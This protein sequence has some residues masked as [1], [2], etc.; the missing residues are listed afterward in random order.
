MQDL[1]GK[2]TLITGGASGVGRATALL[3]A[4]QGAAVSVVDIDQ[5]GGQA[6]V[7]AI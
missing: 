1:A 6:V 5:A 2:R 3:F 7:Q 4:R